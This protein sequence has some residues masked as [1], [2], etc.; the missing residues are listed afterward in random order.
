MLTFVDAISLA[1][2]RNKQNDDAYGFANGR[3]WVLDGATD[4]HD[5]PLS[6]YASDAAWIARFASAYLHGAGGS[7]LRDIVRNVSQAAADAFAALIGGKSYERWQSPISSLV[8]L[9]ESE[10]GVR[11]LDLG[12]SR[13]FA[14]DADGAVHVC[15]GAEGARDAEAAAA[16]KQTDADKPL[17]RRTATIDMLRR[18]RAAHNQPG[19][20]WTFGL[21]PACADHARTWALPLKRPAHVL[22][23]TDG[24]SV[25][26]DQY[27]VYDEAGL[28]Q[29]ARDLGVHELAREIR[30]IENADALGA[31][32]PRFKKSDDATA[33][34]LRLP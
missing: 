8:L 12:D 28:V 16:A 24:F 10:A 7:D 15:G 22:L 21:D 3:V 31:A 25:L 18:G 5:A 33:V 32:H 14:L 9:E 34:L 1:G 6:G 2:D 29:A 30:A 19:A 23:M 20:H 4:L 26:A 17:L 13:L 27:G 11:G